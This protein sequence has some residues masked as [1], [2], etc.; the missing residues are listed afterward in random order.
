MGDE[1]A[2]ISSIWTTALLT[3]SFTL[4]T[5]RMNDGVVKVQLALFWSAR[6]GSPGFGC[7]D[8]SAVANSALDTVSIR[9][10][11]WAGK[12]ARYHIRALPHGLAC[13]SH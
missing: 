5:G 13:T 11:K 6:A 2:Q 4:A 8:G 10:K 3:C 9:L 7:N 12:L 1:I